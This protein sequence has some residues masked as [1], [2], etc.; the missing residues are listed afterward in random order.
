ML[1]SP[2]QDLPDFP[3]LPSE[4]MDILQP[5]PSDR[6]LINDGSPFQGHRF[7]VVSSD[8]QAE[9]YCKQVMTHAVANEPM[10]PEIFRFAFYL[11]GRLR[12]VRASAERITKPSKEEGESKGKREIDKSPME[13][14]RKL[15]A[16][17]QYDIDDP[18]SKSFSC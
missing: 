17:I 14:V 6:E 5:L 18:N 11:Y 13:P 15:W 7:D 1:I 8:P 10:P 12:L 9:H 4:D 16:P 3:D 2:D